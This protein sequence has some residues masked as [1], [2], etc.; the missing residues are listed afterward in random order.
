MAI[1]FKKIAMKETVL[2]E[3]MEGRTKVQKTDGEVHI[4]EF[5]IV[6]DKKGVPYAVCAINDTEFINGGHVLTRIFLSIIEVFSGDKEKAR[7][8]FKAS[9]GIRVKLT[10]K[11]TDGGHDITTVEVLD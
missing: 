6:P 4:T 2:S 11:K 9:G 7:E 10:R 8:E 3:I 1:D 5:D